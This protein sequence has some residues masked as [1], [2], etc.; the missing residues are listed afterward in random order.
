MAKETMRVHAIF[1]FGSIE[2]FATRHS[3]VFSY[4]FPFPNLSVQEATAINAADK[5]PLDPIKK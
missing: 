2:T 4:I 1:V 5:S 3:R